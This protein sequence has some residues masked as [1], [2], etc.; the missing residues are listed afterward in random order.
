MYDIQFYQVKFKII[1]SIKQNT[2]VTKLLLSFITNNI[3]MGEN[4]ITIF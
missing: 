3:F 4:Q 1:F 2:M